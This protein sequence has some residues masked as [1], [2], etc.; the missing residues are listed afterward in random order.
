MKG[1]EYLQKELDSMQ[2]QGIFRNLI[3]LK[4]EQG[5]KRHD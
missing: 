3:E 5:V 2:K 4:S 1:F